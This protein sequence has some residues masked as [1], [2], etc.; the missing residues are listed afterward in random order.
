MK[1]HNGRVREGFGG[2]HITRR[3]SAVPLSQA[4]MRGKG[5]LVVLQDKAGA[6]SENG[7]NDGAMAP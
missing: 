5:E 4:A 6:D 7:G 1:W 3:R 2:L